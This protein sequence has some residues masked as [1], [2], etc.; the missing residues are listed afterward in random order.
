M[1][2]ADSPVGPLGADAIDGAVTQLIWWRAGTLIDGR[3]ISSYAMKWPLTL[4][5]T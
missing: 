4:P 5:V 3:Y 1:I 2:C